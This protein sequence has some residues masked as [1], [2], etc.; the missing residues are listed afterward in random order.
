MK[1]SPSQAYQIAVD[2]LMMRG[3]SHEDAER[4]LA[5]FAHGRLV[6]SAHAL[7][8]YGLEYVVAFGALKSVRGDAAP[9][10][11]DTDPSRGLSPNTL[12]ILG[13]TLGGIGYALSKSSYAHAV[14]HGQPPFLLFH[15]LFAASASCLVWALLKWLRA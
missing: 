1:T 13:I 4:V 7:E 12:V 5:R 14:E 3:L 6:D 15:V 9:H 10:P 11:D 8:R 2:H